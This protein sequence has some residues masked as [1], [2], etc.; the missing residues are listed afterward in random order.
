MSGALII[1]LLS[2]FVLLVTFLMV[3]AIKKIQGSE[4]PRNRYLREHGPICY[5]D[6]LEERDFTELFRQL[7]ASGLVWYWASARSGEVAG[8]S[9]DLKLP[10]E[11][12]PSLLTYQTKRDLQNDFL[13]ENINGYGRSIKLFGFEDTDDPPSSL[14]ET[15]MKNALKSFI[16]EEVSPLKIV[17]NQIGDSIEAYVFVPHTLDPHVERLLETWDVLPN[18]DKYKTRPYKNIKVASLENLLFH[19][20]R[21]D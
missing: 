20:E 10:E 5:E 18:T 9:L 13:E 1:F 17:I 16:A 15:F 21:K 3:Y 14:D 6:Y 11:R 2:L 4:R 12:S 7:Q 19:Y 8:A